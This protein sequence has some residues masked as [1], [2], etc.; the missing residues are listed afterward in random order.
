MLLGTGDI[1]TIIDKLRT[2]GVQKIAVKLG[3]N[4]AVVADREHTYICPQTDVPVVDNIGAGDAFN[5]G[6]L[7]GI[8]EGKSTEQAGHMGSMM[9]S[10]AVCSYGDVEGLPNREQLE[11]YMNHIP[12][13]RR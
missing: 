5:S 12:Q 7:C 3:P 6:F 4:G 11:D 1:D 10:L 2:F 9:G 13:I 8:L